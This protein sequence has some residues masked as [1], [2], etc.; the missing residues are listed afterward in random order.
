MLSQFADSEFQDQR[1]PQGS[2]SEVQKLR[3]LVQRMQD[4]ERRLMDLLNASTPERIEHDLRN[5]LNELVLLRALLD[6]KS[7]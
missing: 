1:S 7:M 4:R 5:V 2:D 6:P 3:V